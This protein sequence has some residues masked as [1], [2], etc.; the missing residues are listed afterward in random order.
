M[1]TMILRTHWAWTRLVV[2]GVSLLAFLMP[3]FAWRMAG[4][5]SSAF[6]AVQLMDG[7]SVLGPL[8]AFLALMGPFVLAVYPWTLDAETNH[9][10]PLTLPITWTRYVG[11][12]YVAGALTLIV[13]AAA[14]YLGSRFVVSLVVLPPLLQAYP[15][16]LAIRFLLAML[17]AYSASFSL[18]YLAGRRATLVALV[19][20]LALLLVATILEVSG[21]NSIVNRLGNLL[22]D[23]RGPFGVFTDTWVLIDV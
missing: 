10:Y 1:F 7:L 12:R 20:L 5:N 6:G 9:V 19:S 17:V 22:F 16:S 11:M 8:L 18:Q 14:L 4:G 15:G 13:P 3:A 23:P 2:A 21:L